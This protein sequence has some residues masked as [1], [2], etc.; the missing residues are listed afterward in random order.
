MTALLLVLFA[1][2]ILVGAPIAIGLVGASLVAMLQFDISISMMPYNIY[3]SIAKF[4]L[5]AIPFFVLA[6]NIMEKVGISQKL[7]DLAK[8]LVGHRRGGMAIVCVGVSCFFA[9]ISGSGPATVAAL[10]LIVIPAM[11]KSGYN[12]G[13]SAALMATAGSIGLIIP[14]SISYILYSSITGVSTGKL[15]I[16]GFIPGILMGTALVIATMIVS[17]KQKLTVMPRASNRDMWIAFKDAFW[18]LMMPV[19]ILGGIYGGIF[20][21]TEAAAV[22]AVYGLIVGVFVYRTLT[23]KS[24]YEILAKSARQ[25]GA[26]LLTVA[27][28]SLFS[29]VVTVGG[30]ADRAITSLT[31]I[32]AGNPVIFLLI[33]N[34]VL[35][36]AGCFVDGNS[37]FY[38]FTPLLYPVARSLGYD[39]IAFGIVMTMNLA[40]GL[41]TPPV[42]LNLYVASG[43]SGVSLSDTIRHVWPF[44]IAS[45]LVLLIVTYF[46]SVYMWLPQMM[47]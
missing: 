36:I 27:M 45:T 38:I 41:V 18:G 11:I 24:F 3:S 25:T 17:S 22:S 4:L 46:P 33:A 7:I 31:N 39:P 13:T 15:F 35:L 1:I 21:A 34:V 28:A 20:T 16:A 40:I 12:E 9:A 6:G 47:K 2:L 37:G 19:I 30:I 26:I 23:F 32:S 43:V 14:P 10:G 8:V 42:G 5:L 29:Y 44:V